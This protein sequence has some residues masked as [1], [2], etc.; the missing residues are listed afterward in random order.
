MIA[1]QR[2]TVKKAFIQNDIGLE[3]TGAGLTLYKSLVKAKNRT[4]RD[5]SYI[6]KDIQFNFDNA[7]RKALIEVINGDTSF[8]NERIKQQRKYEES[9]FNEDYRPSLHR[10]NPNGHY[11][12]GNITVIPYG[13]HLK[14]HA[15]KTPIVM[16]DE[17]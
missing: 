3:Y 7:E 16:I 10:P 5:E 13:E 14:E 9:G 6:K 15:I 8:W 12:F 11:E 2:I 17:H 1:E 4:K